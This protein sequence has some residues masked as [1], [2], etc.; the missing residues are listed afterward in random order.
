MKWIVLGIVLF[1]A[2]YTYLTLHYRKAAP[3]YLPYEDTRDRARAARAGYQ[4]IVG[5]LIRLADP[6]R[7]SVPAGEPAA[8]GL[9]EGLRAALGE[10]VLLPSSIGPVSAGSSADHLSEYPVQFS[11]TLA[12]NRQQVEGAQIFVKGGELFIVP[13]CER[14]AGGLI[15]R[16]REAVMVLGV[17]PGSLPPG[18]YRATLVGERSSR[19]WGLQV[20]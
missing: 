4:R 13:G 1:V 8:G 19:S 12:D 20:H 14:L 7:I 17:P 6:P 10:P 18:R 5:T 2:P 11:C 3:A 16:T 9:P 15:A